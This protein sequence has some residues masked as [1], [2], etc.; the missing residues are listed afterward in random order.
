LIG[1]K[2]TASQLAVHASKLYAQNVVS[3]LTL[4]TAEGVVTP[5]EEDEV[6]QG[7]AVVFNGE[8][9]NAMAREAL[10]LPALATG[11]GE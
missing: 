4:M 2:D 10:N 5:D 9:R 3:L 8:I 11:E 7:S 1:C 6:V